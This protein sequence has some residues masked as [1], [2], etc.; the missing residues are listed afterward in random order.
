MKEL[1]N[2]IDNRLSQFDHYRPKNLATLLDELKTPHYLVEDLIVNGFLYTLT[3]RNN[4]GKTTLAVLLMACIAN[5]RDF[6]KQRTQKG[7]CLFISGE[8]TDDALMKF[9]PFKDKFDLTGIDVITV[10]FDAKKFMKECMA[11]IHDEYSLVVVDSTQAYF[12]EGDMNN[13]TDALNHIK[14]LRELSRM[15]GNPAVISLSHPIKNADMYNLQP[16][17]G[18]AMI[19]EIDGNLTLWLDDRYA[20]LH[21]T[22]L[23]QPS[24]EPIYFDLQ[25][26]DVDWMINNFDKPLTTAYFQPANEESVELDLSEKNTER[27][28]LL[29]VIS[30]DPRLSNTEIG[31][32]MFL[33]VIDVNDKKKI[34]SARIKVVRHIKWLMQEN[35]L[36]KTKTV[37]SSG[38]SFMKQYDSF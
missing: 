26:F 30:Q 19:N 36:S 35:Y 27:A 3:A 23:R 14:A 1:L 20:S 6:G 18:G 24:F 10:S 25:S 13:N 7:K 38:N 37:T 4:S 16:Y 15:R 32:R 31:K 22:K 33:N 9:L 29:F 12:G 5:G 11:T 21:H 28:R 2:I 8:N 17:G 34:E